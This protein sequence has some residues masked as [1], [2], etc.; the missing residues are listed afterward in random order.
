[1]LEEIQ[2][3]ETEISPDNIKKSWKA[4]IENKTLEASDL[5]NYFKDSAPFFLN[6]TRK[7]NASDIG[8]SQKVFLFFLF[9]ER[10]SQTK[11]KQ[12]MSCTK[13]ISFQYF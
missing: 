2:N 4:K 9:Y 1:M 13:R 11:M 10:I 7:D 12:P 3:T 8:E 6:I 5:I